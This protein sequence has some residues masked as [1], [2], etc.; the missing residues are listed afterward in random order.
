MTNYL[1]PL[2]ISAAGVVLLGLWGLQ[3]ILPKL[4]S[5]LSDKEDEHQH[6]DCAE[7][8]GATLELIYTLADEYEAAGCGD[9]AKSMRQNAHKVT[10][11]IHQ[12]EHAK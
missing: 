7:R 6:S 3:Q 4:K 5:W 10:E 11:Y 2:A 9:T 8:M 1:I 12:Q